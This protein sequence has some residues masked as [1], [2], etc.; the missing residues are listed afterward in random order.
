MKTLAE[1]IGE[2]II[3]IVIFAIPVVTTLSWV[4]SWNFRY[5]L[6]VISTVEFVLLFVHINSIVLDEE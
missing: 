1:I 3:S 2:I 6:A 4:Y 5:I